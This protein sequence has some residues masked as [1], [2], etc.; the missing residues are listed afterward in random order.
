MIG[1]HGGIVTMIVVGRVN[2]HGITFSALVIGT[3]LASVCSG[4]SITSIVRDIS[5][6][7]IA[8]KK[9]HSEVCIGDMRWVHI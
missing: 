8:M 7:L 6:N 3:S 1:N 4:D 5:A 9:M 2:H